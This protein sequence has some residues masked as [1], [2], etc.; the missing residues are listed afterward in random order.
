MTFLLSASPVANR[1]VKVKVSLS[2]QVCSLG[3]EIFR[4]NF[5]DILQ[6]ESFVQAMIRPFFPAQFGLCFL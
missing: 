3:P 5:S 2:L 4:E 1:F 6:K